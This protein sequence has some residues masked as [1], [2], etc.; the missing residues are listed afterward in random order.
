V[1]RGLDIALSIAGLI[2]TFPVLAIAAFVIWLQDFRSPFYIAQRVG[3]AGAPFRMFK[4]RSMVA[5]ADRTGVDSTSRTDVRLTPVGSVVRKLKLDEI[6]Q[7]F[8]VLRGEM[9]LVGPRPNVERETRLYT[10]E[11][12]RLLSVRPGITDISSIVF[13]DLGD[14]LSDSGNANLD[15]SQLVRPWKSRLGLLYVDHASF[16]LDLKLI[17]LTVLGVFWRSATLSIL[18]RLARSM[19]AD[20]TLCVVIRREKPLAP[21]PPPGRDEI[22]SEAEVLRDAVVKV[23]V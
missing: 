6:P 20:G 14:I 12:R 17:I 23:G 13:A 15:Y 3:Q 18:A 7:L 19:G 10:T 8:N 2:A 11:E 16:W 5:N 22:V 21:A 1:K 4:L 9:T